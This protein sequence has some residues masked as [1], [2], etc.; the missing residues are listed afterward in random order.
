M[1]DLQRAAPEQTGPD[2]TAVLVR[3][4]TDD[5]WRDGRVACAL[6]R[7]A[8]WP[9]DRPVDR[10]A[11]LRGRFG[12][13]ILPCSA[14]DG[15]RCYFNVSHCAGWIVLAHSRTGPVGVDIEGIDPDLDLSLTATP[16]SLG[17]A[18]RDWLDAQPVALRSRGFLLLWTRKEAL[19]KAIGSGIACSLARVPA[20]PPVVRGWRLRSF[21]SAD[22]MLSVAMRDTAFRCASILG[23]GAS[24]FHEV[25]P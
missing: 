2:L 20:L 18:E 14:P 12:K 7:A 10:A 15:T 4:D 19:L 1:P 13:P 24:E 11:M 9:T 21:A 16:R 5:W 22:A 6:G 25:A 3:S 17:D 8:G 23:D